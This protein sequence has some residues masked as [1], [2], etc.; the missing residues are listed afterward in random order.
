MPHIWQSLVQTLSA[1]QS[2]SQNIPVAR[3]AAGLAV[4]Q[5]EFRNFAKFGASSAR[6]KKIAPLK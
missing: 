4:S 6:K 2:F 3:K 5:F 1:K